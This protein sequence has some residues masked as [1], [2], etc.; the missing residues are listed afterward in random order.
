[1]SR[2]KVGHVGFWHVS[3][4]LHSFLVVIEKYDFNDSKWSFLVA[5]ESTFGDCGA[6]SNSKN[7][8]YKWQFFFV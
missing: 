6:H 1:M 5:V 8:R 4:P 7:K 3:A 2:M